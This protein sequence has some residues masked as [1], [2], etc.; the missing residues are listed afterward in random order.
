VPESPVEVKETRPS[1]PEVNNDPEAGKVDPLLD[2][3]YRENPFFYEV[4]EYFNIETKDYD[5][6]APKLAVIVDWIVE[7][8]DVHKPEDIL[9]KLREGED[10]VQRPGWDEKRYTNLFKYARLA[11]KGNSI[12]KAMSAF[13]RKPNA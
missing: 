2:G 9:M 12:K 11:A 4:A 13:E 7:T 3:Y 1:T 10:M 8:F 6:A 5:V